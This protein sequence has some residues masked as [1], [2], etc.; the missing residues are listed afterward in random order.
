VISFIL[1]IIF[2]T[3]LH[4]QPLKTIIS[5]TSAQLLSIPGFGE[6][7]ASKLHTAFRT[8]FKIDHS[9]RERDKA[10]RE[11]MEDVQVRRE[12]EDGDGDDAEKEGEQDLD[13]PAG[14]MQREESDDDGDDGFSDGE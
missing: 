3:L 12:A 5:S 11:V 13:L 4:A 9:G 7:K 8:P 14:G 2:Y 6:T 1:L 10:R